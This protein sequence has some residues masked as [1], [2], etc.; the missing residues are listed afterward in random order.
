MILAMV[1]SHQA[2]LSLKMIPFLINQIDEKISRGRQFTFIFRFTARQRLQVAIT[3]FPCH[4]IVI[5]REART[6]FQIRLTVGKD[7]N[8]WLFVSSAC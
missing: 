3:F 1:D 2:I 7:R 4:M 8:K 5:D 6:S